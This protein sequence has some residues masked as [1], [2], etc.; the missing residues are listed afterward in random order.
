[1]IKQRSPDAGVAELADAQDSGS[2]DPYTVVEVRLLSPALFI[3]ATAAERRGG[4]FMRP[5]TLRKLP[6]AGRFAGAHASA[7][8]GISAWEAAAD[9]LR[10]R[11]RFGLLALHSLVSHS[12]TSGDS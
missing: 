10:R 4:F 6:E 5:R 7:I 1:M 9:V 11:R 3:K 8:S 2:C 12:N